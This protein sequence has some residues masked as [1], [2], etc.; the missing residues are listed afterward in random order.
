MTPQYPYPA[1]KFDLVGR[2][3]RSHGLK[4]EI[5]VLPLHGPGDQFDNYSRVALVAADGRMTDLLPILRWRPQGNQVILKLDT[6]DSKNEADL[7]VAMGV[8]RS[9]DERPESLSDHGA[10]ELIGLEVVTVAGL[11]VGIVDD[12]IHTGAHP[13][14][15]VISH[16]EEVLI[17]LVD[18]MIVDLQDNRIVI[19][20]PPG[21]L[22]INRT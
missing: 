20:P 21:L 7:T 3:T 2:V 5:K 12:I 10:D 16:T 18:E 17:P 8:L 9:R 22:D 11:S 19:D 13:L 6:I 1:E 15:I 4:G 14:M